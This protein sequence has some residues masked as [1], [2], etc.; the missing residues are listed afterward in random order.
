[1]IA[2]Q[3]RRTGARPGK[4]DSIKPFSRRRS[5][6]QSKQQKL[7]STASWIDRFF[8]WVGSIGMCSKSVAAAV[9]LAALAVPL[10][11]RAQ[12]GGDAPGRFIALGMSAAASGWKHE[13]PD[14]EYFIYSMDSTNGRITVCGDMSG[15]C[16]TVAASLRN[17]ANTAI[18]R[19]AGLGV[20][21]VSKAWK[22]KHSADEHLVHSLDSATGAI[23]ICGDMADVCE[24]LAGSSAPLTDP[25]PNIVVVYRRA[26][27]SGLAGR[28]YDR[29][30][31]HY[32]AGSTFLDIYSI[33]FGVNWTKKVHEAS[34]QG[35]ILIVLIGRKWLGRTGN[36]VRIKEERDPVRSEIE[37]ALA[38]RVP[39]FPVLVDGAS[40]PQASELPDSLQSLRTLN[41]AT[42]DSGRD[43][44]VDMA[45]L[46]V[47]I[48]QRLATKAAR[49]P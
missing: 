33:P 18:G 32:G 30:I 12:N 46:L 22:A 17:A 13:H 29:L 2:M 4:I 26:D 11:A 39:V 35:R 15:E 28:I 5:Q 1:M 21:A 44:D 19:F 27:T 20:T 7:R 25:L 47:A 24:T 9:A 23:Q 34:T 16:R 37:A 49:V 8:W 38:A 14:D 41:A 31:A 6:R 36:H 42:L 48:D 40:M 3:V 45:R 43:F 10:T